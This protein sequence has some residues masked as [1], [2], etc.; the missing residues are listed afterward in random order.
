MPQILFH[1][2][3]A[4]SETVTIDGENFHHVVHVRRQ[5]IGERVILRLPDGTKAETVIIEIH[6]QSI[7]VRITD[8]K[9]PEFS[10]YT[11][12]LA[13][14][15]LKSKKN[16]LIIEKGTEAGITRF[17]PVLYHR[18]IP[19][20]SSIE[21]KI[22]RWRRLCRE[23]S[24]QCDAVYPVSVED[25]ISSEKM[26]QLSSE[27]CQAVAADVH[28]ADYLTREHV[29]DSVI[30]AAGPEGGFSKEEIELMDS[31]NWKR[32]VVH[33]NQMRAETASIVVPAIIRHLMHGQVP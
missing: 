32:V 10:P 27:Y 18:C 2:I 24:K 4:D 25:C 30:V 19:D 3:P 13:M 5:K 26:F 33:T 17:I 6:K 21:K 12:A 11:L 29:S 23:A 28:S 31:Y 8:I 20:H 15:V 22:L 16:D 9:P 7:T 14:P 1:D